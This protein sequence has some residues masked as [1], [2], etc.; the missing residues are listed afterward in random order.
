[1]DVVGLV[2]DLGTE[3]IDLREVAKGVLVDKFIFTGQG[4][5]RLALQLAK[6]DPVGLPGSKGVVF[7][8]DNFNRVAG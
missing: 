1:M 8:Y 7:S 3:V 2:E 5:K 6:G 4:N